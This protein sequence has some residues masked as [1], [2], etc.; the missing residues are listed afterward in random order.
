MKRIIFLTLLAVVVVL[1]LTE[2]GNVVSVFKSQSPNQTQFNLA[3]SNF[4]SKRYQEAVFIINSILDNANPSIP[5]SELTLFRASVLSVWKAQVLQAVNE[6]I[7]LKKYTEALKIMQPILKYFSADPFYDPILMKLNKTCVSFSSPAVYSGPIE[8]IFFHP[9][10]TYSKV[11]S[12]AKIG[13]DENMVTIDEFK[14]TLEQF[15]KANYVLIDIHSIY[16][17]TKTGKVFRKT[18]SIPKGKKP[19]VL[20]IDDYNFLSYMKK[21]GCAEGLGLVNGKVLSYITDG[22]GKRTYSDDKEITPILDKFVE[23][24]PDFSYGGAK[25]IIALEGYEGAMGFATNHLSSPQY[26]KILKEAKTVVAKLKTSG[27][28]FASHSYGHNSPSNRS[29][30][31]MLQDAKHWIKEVGKVVGKTDIYVYPFGER[32]PRSDKKFSNLMKLGF[33]M[34]CD[35]WGT[36]PDLEFKSNNIRM[37]RR[38]VDGIE[39]RERRLSNIIDDSVIPS[40]VRPWF[41]DFISEIKS[42]KQMQKQA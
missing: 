10:M 13:F 20:S 42:K 16:G 19:L 24:N 36:H 21:S 29:V 18:L 37:S 3:K 8:H 23:K 5:I 26:P 14:R 39:L 17:T 34:F 15:Y 2:Y 31:Y 1:A 38:N 4:D 30:A 33:R 28:I 41:K 22:T 25:G 40:K 6:L 9:L 32:I 27:W 12:Y 7:K 11:Q 35:V